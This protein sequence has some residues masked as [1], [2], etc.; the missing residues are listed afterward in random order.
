MQT[1]DKYLPQRERKI[2]FRNSDDAVPG[3]VEIE[4]ITTENIDSFGDGLEVTLETK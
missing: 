1:Y 3:T 4:N 2:W